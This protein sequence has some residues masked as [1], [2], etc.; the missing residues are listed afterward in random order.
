MTL[1]LYLYYILSELPDQL[2]QKQITKP[3]A[4][5]KHLSLLYFCGCPKIQFS[6]CAVKIFPILHLT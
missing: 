6:F 5:N 4:R 3:I 1:N 2:E